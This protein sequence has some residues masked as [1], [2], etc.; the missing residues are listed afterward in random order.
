MALEKKKEKIFLLNDMRKWEIPENKL[1]MVPQT[2]L[3]KKEEAFM[4]MLPKESQ[5]LDKNL[6]NYAFYMSQYKDNAL[7]LLEHGTERFNDNFK[8]FAINIKVNAQQV[9]REV[10]SLLGFGLKWRRILPTRLRSRN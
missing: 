8:E 9:D 1:S 6:L 7:R 4:Y 3:K 10:F 5:E 2:T